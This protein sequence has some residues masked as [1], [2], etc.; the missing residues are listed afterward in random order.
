[1][2]RTLLFALLAL[3]MMAFAQVIDYESDAT[4]Q[5][6]VLFGGALDGQQAAV[7]ANPDA[8]GANTSA[9]VL[10]V[11]KSADAPEWGGM[12]SDPRRAVDALNGGS[13]CMDVW[14]DHETT[15][16]LK[17]EFATFDDPANYEMDAVSTTPS[18][19]ETIC[20]DLNANS[21][22]GDG[23]PGA[24]K[25]FEH[26][27]IFPD[28][29]VPGSGEE[30][31][32]YIDNITFPAPP[33]PIECITLYDFETI[34][35]DSFSTFGAMD[36]T[37]LAS[38][39]VIPNPAPDAVNGTANVMRYTK[40]GEAQTWAGF[41]WDM[42]TPIDANVAF[43]VCMDYWSPV[44]GQI[45]VKLENGNTAEDWE[46]RAANTAP[47]AWE[48]L[49]VDLKQNSEGANNM[50]SAVGRVF[51]RMVL[52]P[53][54]DVAGTGTDV[55]FY[56]D[57]IIVKNDNTVRD[58][59]VTFSV[60]MS[61]YP[62]PFMQVYVSGTF[63]S[64]SGTESPLT[65]DD[66]DG[67]WSGT[68][69]VSQGALEYKFTVDDWTDEERLGRFDDCVKVTD[70]GAGT[71]FVNRGAVIAADTELE[72]QCWNACYACGASYTVTWNVSFA[73]VDPD[74]SGLFVA[75]GCCFSNSVYELTDEDGDGIYS[76]TIRREAGFNSYYTFLNGACADWSCKEDI[77]G[78]DCSDPNNFNDRFLEPLTGDVVIN[79]CYGQCTDVAEC[80]FIPEVEMN[81]YVDMAGETISPDGVRIAGSFTNWQDEE[82]VNENGTVYRYTTNLLAGDYEYKF[83]NG[84]DGWEAFNDGD[85]CTITTDDG[86]GNIFI[87]RALTI[88]GNNASESTTTFCFD[89]CES[90]SVGV[91]DLEIDNSLFA[92]QPTIAVEHFD[93]TFNKVEDS[94]LS[95]LG[96]NGQL[97]STMS[98]AK[99]TGNLRVDATNL[100]TGMYF[101]TLVSEKS[102]ATHRVVVSK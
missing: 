46:L 58:Y 94:Q 98:I 9:T 83:K 100:E 75:G 12:A 51:T 23:T 86:S 43:E 1:M 45:L 77:S 20:F 48:T 53:E 60:D 65:D 19:W 57:N 11:K 72:A 35:P 31:T 32:Y 93:L 87:N 41:F 34:S 4:S 21:V 68:F 59:N 27:V 7:I 15:F 29:G 17:L 10:E 30:S 6:F 5:G 82:M 24:G 47:G 14:S 2:K 76:L 85:P 33:E 36:T 54:M 91:N 73:T 49:C 8:S 37:L 28:F 39:F 70:D 95:I 101:M 40:Q 71:V 74:P 78:Q 56:I 42:N 26:L 62:E 69:P 61:E 64:W 81:F 66:G 88:S 63:N 18:Q 3:P 92:V 52:F 38:E 44:S 99:G 80:E 96:T 102:I 79:T 50:A 22:A 67:V 16:R 84:P 55:D 89:T 97:I 13:I 90:C 25:L